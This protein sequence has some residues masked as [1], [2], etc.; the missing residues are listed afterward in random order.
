MQRLCKLLGMDIG[1]RAW[2]PECLYKTWIMKWQRKWNNK[3]ETR[4][5]MFV[6]KDSMYIVVPSEFQGSR[7]WGVRFEVRIWASPAQ[8]LW[9]PIKCRVQG[10]RV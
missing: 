7:V 8:S 10:V 9:N 1:F 3:M 2:G 6:E 5:P 4:S